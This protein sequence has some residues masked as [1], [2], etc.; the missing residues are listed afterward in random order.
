ML[1]QIY[2]KIMKKLFFLL[3]FIF[4]ISFSFAQ[5]SDKIVSA[6][7]AYPNPFN[8]QERPITIFYLLDQDAD[9]SIE[10][11]NVDGIPIRQFKF[12]SGAIGGHRGANSIIWDGKDEQGKTL[13]DDVYYT[14]ISGN[15]QDPALQ[16]I[17]K[18]VGSVG[19]TLTRIIPKLKSGE[20]EVFARDILASPIG[21]IK[22][23]NNK[24]E[25]SAGEIRIQGGVKGYVNPSQ[26]EVALIHFRTKN[27]GKVGVKIYTLKGRLIWE[28]SKYTDGD[29][30]FIRWTGA[31]S[32]GEVVPSGVYII[33]IEG[34]G[35][36]TTKKVAII[37]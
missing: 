34:P 23:I 28:N 25:L 1:E 19:N 36:R 8:S 33:F 5:S 32:D 20:Y 10:I 16:F 6:V 37:R 22:I 4:S 35:I 17:L 15:S 2:N 14:L 13:P 29:E 27:S 30:D 26:G 11:Y 21:T 24:K 12:Y 7:T 18:N 31:N 3:I 9:V